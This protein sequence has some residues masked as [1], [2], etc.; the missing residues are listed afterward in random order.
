MIGRLPEAAGTIDGGRFV[1]LDDHQRDRVVADIAG[2]VADMPV[3]VGA[4]TPVLVVGPGWPGGSIDAEKGVL[5]RSLRASRWRGCRNVRSAH[6]RAGAP[7]PWARPPAAGP[8]RPCPAGRGCRAEGAPARPARSGPAPSL[9]RP[10][11]VGL[12]SSRRIARRRRPP[13]PP[14]ASRPCACRGCRDAGYGRSLHPRRY[15]GPD[16]YR[17]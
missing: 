12:R 7:G 6:G 1:Q 8:A 9:R 14:P 5:V 3:S 13:C 4:G 17:S 11:S 2:I 16:R 15:N 10:G